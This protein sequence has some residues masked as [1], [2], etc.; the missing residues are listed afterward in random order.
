MPDGGDE[1]TLPAAVK[2]SHTVADGRYGSDLAWL[3]RFLHGYRPL[4]M[5]SFDGDDAE[6]PGGREI[7]A[8]RQIDGGF[9]RFGRRCLADVAGIRIVTFQHRGRRGG[10]LS[11]KCRV[12]RES[13]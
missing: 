8:V 3:M 11:G 10:A 1:R 12:R 7:C 13:D 5:P 4:P 2:V 6:R 9:D